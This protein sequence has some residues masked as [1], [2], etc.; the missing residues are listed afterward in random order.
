MKKTSIIIPC[1]NEEKNIKQLVRRFLPIKNNFNIE[2]ILVDNGSNDRTREKILAY[3]NQFDFIKLAE[4]KKN[5]G[6]GYG[7]LKG[8]QKAT[9]EYLGWMHADLQSNPNIFCSMMNCAVLESESFLFKGRRKK[10]PAADTFFTVGMSLFETLFLHRILWD[11]NA[12]PTLFDRKF[13]MQWE[14]APYDFSLDLYAYYLAKINGIKIVRFPSVHYKRQNGESTW[15][16]GIWARIRL[17]K[18]VLAYSW[19]L[20]KSVPN[21]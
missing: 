14:N 2:L 13:Y 4:V 21:K 20:K 11:I 16:T 5:K 17:I 18:R 12:Q 1:Y 19:N 3:A 7:I 6:Y 9:G 10:R 15:N 8:L